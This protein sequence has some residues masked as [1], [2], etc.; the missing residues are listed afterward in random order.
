MYYFD[1]SASTPPY[2]EVAEVYKEIMGKY[3]GNPS[4]IHHLG[5]E[6]EKLL[7]KAR[8]VTSRLL[9]INTKEVVFTSGG[10]ESNNLAIKGIAYEYQHRGKHLITTM[11]EHASVY[12]CFKQ[13]ESQGFE[14][15][16][17]P[18]DERG[19]VS[20]QQ[21]SEALRPDTIL[22]SIMHVNNEMGSIQMVE[23]IGELLQSFPHVLFHVDA[24]QSIGKV[25]VDLQKW[26]ADAVSFSAHKFGG[27]RGV[28]LL[29]KRSNVQLSPLFVG[30]GQE[31]GFR[32][33]TENVAGI[34]AMTKALRIS[35]ERQPNAYDHITKLRERLLQWLGPCADV[36]L[37]THE[38]ALLMAPH[39]VNFSIPVTKAEVFVHALE[40]HHIYIS[41]KSA[42]SSHES[43]PS[44]VILAM[45]QDTVRARSALRVSLSDEHS[46]H[47]IDR[48]G[49][50]IKE[51]I[52]QF[53]TDLI[54]G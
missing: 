11:I 20:L 32:S 46:E 33:G 2:N 41:T 9:N 38:Q 39:I 45:Y 25:H 26:Q 15:T 50:C 8:E 51:T 44:R 4:S 19:L 49:Q 30:G 22:V 23:A 42:C 16:Y 37:N 35:L 12:E 31:H 28:G 29:Y 40:K 18:V 24:V 48:L 54:R 43:K 7:N 13:L 52:I 17:L 27:P 53:K 36:M 21:L 34:V 1:H 3:F 14:V 6:S 47:D 5:V 10:T